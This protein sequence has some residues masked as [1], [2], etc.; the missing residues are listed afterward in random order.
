M[1]NRVLLYNIHDTILLETM[2]ICGKQ[3][4]EEK[5]SLSEK[6]FFYPGAQTNFIISTVI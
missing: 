1:Y 5:K 4:E 6:R 2:E 3:N